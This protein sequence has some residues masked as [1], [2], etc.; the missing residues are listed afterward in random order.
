MIDEQAAKSMS[1]INFC[2]VGF[3]LDFKKNI[4]KIHEIKHFLLKV[5]GATNHKYTKMYISSQ[6]YHQTLMDCL[7][8]D[9][10]CLPYVTWQDKLV[11]KDRNYYLSKRI[12]YINL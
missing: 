12:L 9:F 11:N 7:Q 8:F 3:W 1:A 6:V 5:L 2:E 4:H 10:L